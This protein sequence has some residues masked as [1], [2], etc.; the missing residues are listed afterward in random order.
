MRHQTQVMFDQQVA[1][2]LIA[3]GH[4]LQVLR[5][6]LFMQRLREG[7]ILD[8]RDQQRQ[9]FNEQSD[10]SEQSRH[11][12][13]TPKMLRLSIRTPWRLKTVLQFMWAVA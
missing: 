2:M 9:L 8:V 4:Q 12:S 13:A 10:R 7:V 3:L 1:R 11:E 5:F 6:F